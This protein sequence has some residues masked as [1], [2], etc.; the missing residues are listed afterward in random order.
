MTV[1]ISNWI[2]CLSSDSSSVLLIVLSFSGSIKVIIWL[3]NSTLKKVVILSISVSIKSLSIIKVERVFK[4]FVVVLSEGFLISISFEELEDTLSLFV[5]QTVS[6]IVPILS[7][8]S[9]NKSFYWWK[10]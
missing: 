7:K 5:S 6:I 2:S 10:I 1:L 4:F 3:Y 9:I 8:I